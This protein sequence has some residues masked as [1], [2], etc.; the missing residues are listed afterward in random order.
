MSRF[1]KNYD[2]RSEDRPVIVCGKGRTKQSFRD[3][4]D[5]NNI[6]K[7]YNK[8]GQLPGLIKTNP[9]YGDFSEVGTYQDALAVVLHAQSQFEGLPSAV[10]ARFSNDPASFLAFATNPQN[11]EEM[12]RMGL[13]TKKKEKLVLEA[14]EEVKTVSKKRSKKDLG[15]GKGQG[16]PAKEGPDA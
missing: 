14:E 15:P 3:D 2:P 8:T 6:L 9:Q 13:A 5:I 16:A 7:K 4:C 12:V 10:R 11:G 1:R